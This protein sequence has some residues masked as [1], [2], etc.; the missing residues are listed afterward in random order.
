[1]RNR[2]LKAMQH[3]FVR[4]SGPS[5]RIIGEHY[6]AGVQRASTGSIHLTKETV[7]GRAPLVAQFE[8][9][10]AAQGALDQLHQTG[11]RNGWL[12]VAK[13]VRSERGTELS[14][15][16]GRVVETADNTP[17]GRLRRSISGAPVDEALYTALIRRGAG[18]A[19]ARRIDGKLAPGNAVITV[20]THGRRQAVIQIIKRRGGVVY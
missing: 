12:A 3:V 15:L 18:D 16:R 19:V 7:A 8:T 10:E 11:F 5:P 9:E 4:I 6:F 13:D 14:L 1:M 17:L 2:A 20:E